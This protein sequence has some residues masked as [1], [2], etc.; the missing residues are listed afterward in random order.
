VRPSSSRP[1][2]FLKTPPHLVGR[3]WAIPVRFRSMI[4][5]IAIIAAIA[6]NFLI[7]GLVLALLDGY[8]D[9]FDWYGRTPSQ[10][11]L[12]AAIFF[13]PRMLVLRVRAR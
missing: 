13:W 2:S 12:L 5:G 11:G 8:A 1:E 7:G 9:V 10:L 4:M 3:P 6:V